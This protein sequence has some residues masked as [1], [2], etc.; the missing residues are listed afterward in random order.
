[1]PGDSPRALSPRAFVLTGIWPDAALAEHHG[2]RVAQALARR[3]AMVMSDR[4]ISANRLARDSG[5]NRQT[6]A[7]VL[8]GSG[9]PDLLTIASLERALE[10][11][12]WPGRA[13]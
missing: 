12:L 5:I 7:N 4:S 6:I 10:T 9:W 13:M 2:A 1:M 3:L 8:A 11:D